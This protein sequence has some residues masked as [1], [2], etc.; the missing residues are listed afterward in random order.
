MQLWLKKAET[1]VSVWVEI[2]AYRSHLAL[3]GMSSPRR[4]S[5]IQSSPRA[6]GAGR[7]NSARLDG[8]EQVR[9]TRRR[10]ATNRCTFDPRPITAI[11]Y[12][13]LKPVQ[14]NSSQT[15]KISMKRRMNLRVWRSKCGPPSLGAF[16]SKAKK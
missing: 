4:A 6:G 16:E 15:L 12:H 11:N 7:A 10:L 13:P 5:D 9:P 8:V 2:G 1:L 14:R 3:P